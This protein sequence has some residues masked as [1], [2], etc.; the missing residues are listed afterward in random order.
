MEDRA[1]GER[2]AALEALHGHVVAGDL[3][4]LLRKVDVLQRDERRNRP[5]LGTDERTAELAGRDAVLLRG[6]IGDRAEVVVRHH[7]DRRAVVL[8]DVADER[9]LLCV[10]GL[11]AHE[12]RVN[13]RDRSD[14][15]E[16][17]RHDRLQI[18]TRE[19]RELQGV[20]ALLERHIL[21]HRLEHVLVELARVR[22]VAS[23][24]EPG[25]ERARNRLHRMQGCRSLVRVREERLQPAHQAAR[26][27]DRVVR[28]AALDRL[29]E[30]AERMLD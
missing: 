4:T 17:A 5:E 23:E 25:T 21:Q 1:L 28:R 24:A 30:R 14:L 9:L 16:P 26:P 11:G 19:H 22:D 12:V 13:A 29:L 7:A 10:G 2:I 8:E 15:A 18:E 20:V 3:V 27:R 6:R